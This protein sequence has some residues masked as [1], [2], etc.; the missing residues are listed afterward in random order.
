MNIKITLLLFSFPFFLFSQTFEYQEFPVSQNGNNLSL[1]FSG[2][3]NAPQFSEV[4]LNDDGILDLYVFDRVGNVHSTFIN[5]GIPNQ[6]SYQFAYEYV[7]NFPPCVHWVAL[8]D[9]NQ[10]GIYDIFTHGGD[11][12][13]DG[14]RVFKGRYE[15]G[16][17]A[18]DRIEFVQDFSFNVLTYPIG[19]DQNNIYITKLDYPAFAD[20]DGDE[21]MDILTFN[22]TGTYVEFFQNQSVE[23]G[24]GLDTLIFK[25]V[26]NC[27]GKFKESSFTPTIILSDDSNSCADGLVGNDDEAKNLHSGS[28]LLCYDANNDGAMELVIGDVANQ[29]LVHLFNEGSS[30]AAWMT[31]Q[32]ETFS[33]NNSSVEIPYFVASYHLDLNND[34]LKDFVASPNNRFGTLDRNVAWYYP[35]MT[36]NELPDFQFAQDNF[37]VGEM[38]DLGSNAYPAFVD[39][40]GDA[41]IDLVVGNYTEYLPAGDID[42]RLYLFEN[43]GTQ[44]SPS[45]SLV[46]EDWLG[47]NQFSGLGGGFA[48]TFGDL[49]DDGDL[50][51]LV[52]ER[53]GHLF[54]FENIAGEFNPM[55]FADPIMNWQDINVGQNST[56]QIIDMNG[57]DLPDLVIGE[58]NGNVN[59]F[60]NQGSADNPVFHPIADEAPNQNNFGNINTRLPGYVTGYSAPV[61]VHMSWDSY[62]IISGSENGKLYH[63]DDIP[64]DGSL[65]TF[66]LS[67]DDFGEIRIGSDSHPAFADLNNDGFLDMVVGNRRGGLVAFETNLNPIFVDAV[68]ERVS[69][70]F[71]VFPNPAQDFLNF[72]WDNNKRERFSYKIFNSIG[73]IILDNSELDDYRKIN[74]SKLPV[75]VYFLEINSK[76]YSSSLRFIKI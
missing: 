31:S 45:F 76:K 28:T 71:Q 16:K 5:E 57:D 38:V 53:F 7:H 69:N 49:D 42:A 70:N 25:R 40:N 43:V 1:P 20:V 19:N 22:F 6:P 8:R 54:Y 21:D 3:M 64:L 65:D 47:L 63:F 10:D 2:G 30:S 68:E 55:E 48:P 73:Q 74:I 4:D 56:P 51:A 32:D 36:S 52:G 23:E 11:E 39:Y 33:S 27:W 14:V 9:F 62:H 34:D 59:F 18:F 72:K 44:Q 37:L 13:V 61:F 24:F 67:S 41:K 75:G 26:D 29:F 12:G 15:D 46:D 17:I 58:R 35:N 66:N 60:P 50:D